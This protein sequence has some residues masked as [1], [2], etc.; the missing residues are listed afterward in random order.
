MPSREITVRD[1]TIYL[2]VNDLLTPSRIRGK[3][4]DSRKSA[5]IKEP[6]LSV[7]FST[8]LRTTST[9]ASAFNVSVIAAQ[10]A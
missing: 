10:L 9:G 8:R 5:V 1:R 6:T 2:A 7:L 3:K 4:V